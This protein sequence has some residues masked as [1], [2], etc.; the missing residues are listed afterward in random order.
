MQAAKIRQKPGDPSTGNAPRS[1][2]SLTAAQYPQGARRIRSAPRCASSLTAA[3]YPQGARCIRSAPRCASSLTAAQHPQN[4]CKARCFYPKNVSIFVSLRGRS[5]A[6]A[7][8]K[9]KARHPAPKYGSTK[10]GSTKQKG[11]PI[12]KT[13][14][15]LRCL[16]SSF[17][18]SRLCFVPRNH[19]SLRNDKSFRQRL[20][21]RAQKQRPPRNDK[22]DRLD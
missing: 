7:I 17:S 1:A 5:A 12:T 15:S 13:M 11:T 20:P 18:I 3:Q 14:D 6:V 2:S 22:I 4:P 21:R 10:H 9:P 8:F 19:I 16:A